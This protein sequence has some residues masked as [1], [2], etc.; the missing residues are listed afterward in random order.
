MLY[1]SF[2][3]RNPW[4]NVHR[5]IYNRFWKV[6]KNKTIEVGLYRNSCILE[7]SFGITNFKQD[8]AGFSFDIG[9]LGYNLD[10]TF[11]DNRHYNER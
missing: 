3:L 8:H 5:M 7:F 1:L 2:S 11:Y 10:L 9:L 4:S 6:S